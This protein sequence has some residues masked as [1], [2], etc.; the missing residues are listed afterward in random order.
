MS[1]RNQ[2][3]WRN[4]KSLSY[5]YHGFVIICG[6]VW[7][8]SAYLQCTPKPHGEVTQFSSHGAFHISMCRPTMWS[9]MHEPFPANYPRW[10]E[11]PFRRSFPISCG[12]TLLNFVRVQQ[13][14]IKTWM[15]IACKQL[16]HLSLW[17]N[18]Y[19]PILDWLKWKNTS[20]Q[21]KLIGYYFSK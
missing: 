10:F 18:L 3:T 11:L 6:H 19:K 15:F 16:V 2:T 21:H 9:R 13:I 17:C 8:I 1:Y 12:Y 4:M 20:K 7:T 14:I 5:S